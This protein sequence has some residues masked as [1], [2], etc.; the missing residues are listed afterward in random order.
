MEYRG[1]R[2]DDLES[3]TSLAAV[4]QSDTNTGRSVGRIRSPDNAAYLWSSAVKEVFAQLHEFDSSEENH[5]LLPSE[6]YV[7]NL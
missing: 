5:I 3:R 7:S 6:I 1:S 2:G 4:F